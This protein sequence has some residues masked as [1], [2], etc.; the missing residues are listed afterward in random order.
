ME[1]VGAVMTR[2]PIV[3]SANATT[4]G[5]ARAMRDADL[6]SAVVVYADTFGIVTEH[7][8]TVGA[9]AEGGDPRQ[10]EVGTLC[11]NGVVALHPTQTIAE[12]IH[13]MRETGVRRLPVVDDGTP[14]GIVVLGDLALERDL[15]G[16][17]G[18]DSFFFEGPSGHFDLRAQSLV[19][20]VQLAAVVSD[21][22]WLRHLREGNYSRWFADVI[23]DPVLAAEATVLESSPEMPA[24]ESRAEMRAAIKRLY[25]AVS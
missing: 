3:V 5:V 20:F 16:D 24:A 2:E 25:S 1:R 15:D 11:S 7:D 21:A 13:L 10:V 8:I 19:A 17:L 9:V 6:D 12:A 18:S 23:N 4:V 22:T 14:V